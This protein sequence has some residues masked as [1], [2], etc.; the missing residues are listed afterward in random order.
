MSHPKRKRT[1][2]NLDV[3]DGTVFPTAELGDSSVERAM[4]NLVQLSSAQVESLGDSA[5]KP[6]KRVKA[7][8]EGS[9]STEQPYKE[10]K[11]AKD[12]RPPKEVK[13]AKSR[14]VP[15]VSE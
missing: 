10:A 9:E 4:H 3:L 13:V 11:A 14:E 2:V 15:I 1:K 8:R 5:E 7:A 12:P 6:K